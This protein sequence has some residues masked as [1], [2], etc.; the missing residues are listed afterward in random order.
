VL[1]GLGG[2][3]IVAQRYRRGSHALRAEG[4][5]VGAITN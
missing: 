1:A 3:G 4:Y 5:R 2:E